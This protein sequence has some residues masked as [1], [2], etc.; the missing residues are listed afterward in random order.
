MDI[1]THVAAGALAGGCVALMIRGAAA[2]V[3]AALSWGALGGFLP[4][5]DAASRVPGFDATVGRAF[6]LAPGDLV[7]AGSDWYSHHHFTHSLVAAIGAALL[8]AGL[9][10]VERLIFGPT[11]DRRRTV[12][13]LMAPSA[14]LAGFLLHLAGD[15]VTPASVWGGIQLL[16]PLETMVGGWG[17][18]WWFNNYDIFLVQ[19]MGLGLLGLASL[20]PRTRP[21]LSRSLPAALL[22]SALLA[23]TALLQLR[24]H[25]YAYVGHASDYEALEQASLDDQRRL[26][27]ADLFELM[28]SFDRA[29]PL[30]F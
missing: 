8:V 22:L 30:P 11:P 24:Q 9:L 6:G 14:L 27:P 10:G 5:I 7:Y 3:G 4:D 19:V 15:L 26:L 20:V 13:I 17:W 23:S 29:M 12:R 1:F 25:D 18:C 16:W 21:V 28:I 2:S